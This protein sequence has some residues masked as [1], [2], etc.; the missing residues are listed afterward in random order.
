MTYVPADLRREVI[1]RAS[2][3]C[4]YCRRGQGDVLFAFHVEHIT[5]EKHGGQTLSDNLALSCPAC[6]A[7]KGTDVAAADPRTGQATFLFHP[8]RQQWSDHFR[9]NGA[10]IE[11][12]TPEGRVT[13]FLLRLN[14][15]QRIAE[16]ISLIKLDRYP[17]QG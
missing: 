10:V 4:E 17:C 11:P 7:Y 12:L 5:A 9:L 1:E 15:P 8:R 14:S 6:N 16:R 2:N 13:V 3:C